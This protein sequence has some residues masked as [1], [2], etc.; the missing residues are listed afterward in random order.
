MQDEAQKCCSND[1]DNDGNC[2]QHPA[3]CCR[4]KAYNSEDV[5]TWTAAEFEAKAVAKLRNYWNKIESIKFLLRDGKVW[6]AGE[7]IQ[8]LSDGITFL[9]ELFEQRIAS[10]GGSKSDAG[11]N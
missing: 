4:E 6:V 11:S 9:V 7:Q 2:H 5:T 1:H 10:S 8:G 3:D